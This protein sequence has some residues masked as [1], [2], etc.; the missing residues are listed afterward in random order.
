MFQ[1]DNEAGH[2]GKTRGIVTFKVIKR[3]RLPLAVAAGIGM[4]ATAWFLF[5]RCC[6]LPLPDAQ[7][8]FAVTVTDRHGRPLRR[9]ADADGVWRWPVELEDVSPRYLQA[10]ISY[11]DRWFYRHPGINPFSLLRAFITNLRAR[12]IISGGSTLSMQTARLIDPHPRTLAGKVRQMLRA[13]QLEWHFSKDQILTFYLNHAPFGGAIEGV[14]AAA[15]RYLGKSARHLTHA[16]A[17]LLAVLPQAPSRL[18]P[19]RHP[20]RAMRA[21]DK[22]LARLADFGVWDTVTVA[23]ARQE[24]VL[25]PAYQ[26][27]MRA[28]LLA[29]RLQR[30]YPDRL[31]I[32]TGIDAAIQQ[33]VADILRRHVS[34]LP[35]HLSAAALVVQNEDLQ[36]LAYAGSADFLDNS[37]YGHVD[38]IQAVRSPGSTLKPFLYGLALDEGMIHSES[39]LMDA[40][41]NFDGYQ[42]GNFSRHFHGPV[43]VTEALQR[44]LNLPAV[45]LLD[46]LGPAFF[47]RRLRQG[48]LHVI[49]PAGAKPNLSMILGGVGVTLQNLVGCYRALGHGGMAG[50]VRFGPQDPLLET[51]MFSRGAAWIIDRLLSETRRPDL[52]GGDLQL[53]RGR[54]VAWKTG[55]SYGLRDAWTIGVTDQ[56]TVGVWVGRP[57]GT[58]APGFYGRVSAAPLLFQIID[59]LPRVARPPIPSPQSVSRQEICWPLGRAAR[60]AD[61]PLC[62]Q[63]RMAWVLDGAVPPTLPDRGRPQDSANPLIVK[64]NPA[65][66]LRLSPGCHVADASDQSIARWPQAAASW[67]PPEINI[68]SSVPALDPLCGP[69]RVRAPEPVAILGLSPGAVLRGIPH[70]SALPLVTLQAIGGSG[71]IDWLLNGNRIGRSISGD[72]WA[73]QFKAP[74]HYRVTAM[75]ASGNFDSRHL[76]VVSAS[77]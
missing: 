42:P 35:A 57:D 30:R 61:D 69:P 24:R 63:R 45:D 38:M 46:R 70:R 74:G 47:D 59:A 65:T 43:S 4:L 67:L 25:P 12:K 44:S 50:Q 7:A 41:M 37:R 23:E 31:V 5:D 1:A 9:F 55:T 77:H 3:F 26:P 68:R 62:H 18:R 21:R 29:R 58:P 28:P 6:P 53:L 13:L 22:V 34:G 51:R 20:G 11:E 16:E 2:F 64:I 49:Y 32:Q 27:D 15:F 33:T 56:F 48:G 36:T 71:A 52:P 19:D 54:S 73:Y 14:Q 39:L 72:S 75:D 8:G 17:A 40:P 76:T 60:H 66:G 10:L